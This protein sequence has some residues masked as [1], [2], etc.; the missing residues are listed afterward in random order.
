MVCV[1][2][3]TKRDSFNYSYLTEKK[4]AANP[5][6]YIY[7]NIDLFIDLYIY[8]CVTYISTYLSTHISFFKPNLIHG[9]S[10]FCHFLCSQLGWEHIWSS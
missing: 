9:E 7:L 10:E 4:T 6:L 1:S 2:T 8:L 5:C 3:I